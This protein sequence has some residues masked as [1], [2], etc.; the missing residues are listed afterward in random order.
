MFD[1]PTPPVPPPPKGVRGGRFAA[2]GRWHA[3]S[4]GRYVPRKGL[5]QVLVVVVIDGRDH[6]GVLD[7][8]EQL[9][10]GTWR[11]H[12]VYQVTPEPDPTSTAGGGFTANHVG[13]FPADR[14]RPDLTDHTRP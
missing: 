8:W 13:W 1:W 10:D 7:A 2:P 9:D 4:M 3:V 5:D 6:S 11:G 12:V 14:I